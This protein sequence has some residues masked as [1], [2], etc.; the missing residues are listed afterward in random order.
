MIF[1]NN[2]APLQSSFPLL[3]NLLPSLQSAC[4]L[5]RYQEKNV[6]RKHLLRSKIREEE[7]PPKEINVKSVKSK[8]SS[9]SRNT[10]PLVGV[11]L[12][13]APDSK[14]SNRGVRKFH[15]SW[16]NPYVISFYRNISQTRQCLF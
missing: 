13:S 7:I 12:Y 14:N 8:N 15:K 9:C 1:T 16:Y 4:K 11:E 6:K 3:T 2:R 10:F 5:Y